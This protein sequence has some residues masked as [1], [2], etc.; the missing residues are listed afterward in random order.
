M[1]AIKECQLKLGNAKVKLRDEQQLI[2]KIMSSF[3]C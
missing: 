2:D 3:S 1:Y